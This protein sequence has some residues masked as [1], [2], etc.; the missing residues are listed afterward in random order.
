MNRSQFLDA[1]A[2]RADAHKRDVEHVWEAAVAVIGEAV[3]KGDPVGITG[4]G[5]FGQR[6]TKAR[7]AGLVRNPFTGEMV[8]AAAR[9][10]M[11]KPK[12]TPAKPFKE[13]VSGSA[14]SLP[15]KN[16][17]PM[18]LASDDASAKKAPAKKKPAAKKATAR[19][20][21]AKKPAARK[22]AARKS[23]AKKP[24]AR[25]TTKRR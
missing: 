3:K 5:K 23:A 22:P 9:P 24:A 25:K 17:R 8:K 7:K 12:F 10:A 1:V 15:T 21:A 16:T 13:F 14:K 19:K 11:K 2:K 6:V 18:A 4:F 20:S